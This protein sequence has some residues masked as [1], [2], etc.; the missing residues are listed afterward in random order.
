MRTFHYII[1]L[2][3]IVTLVS[4]KGNKNKI[5]MDQEMYN[6]DQIS[7]MF[8]GKKVFTFTEGTM[9]L[10]FN[11]SLKQ[12]RAGNDDMSSYFV[13]TC[14]ELP[15]TVGQEVRGEIK[16]TSGSSVKT[17]SGLTFKVEKYEDTG[18]VWLWCAAD[19]TGAVVKIL[20]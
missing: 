7:L 15:T 12:F 14:N 20:N 13:I 3:A 6:S 9:Q 1:L 18:L 16:W 17:A 8:N 10:G 4:C 11:R 2:T 19:K 5:E